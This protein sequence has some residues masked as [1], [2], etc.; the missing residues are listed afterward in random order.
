MAIWRHVGRGNSGCAPSWPSGVNPCGKGMRER[1]Y[2]A[3]AKDSAANDGKDSRHTQ[4]WRYG[5]RRRAG[6]AGMQRAPRRYRP[7][8]TERQDAGP[9][10]RGR[11]RG[12]GF[13]RRRCRGVGHSPLDHAAGRRGRFCGGAG[14]ENRHGRAGLRRHECRCAGNRAAHCGPVP[15]GP[16]RGRRHCRP[17]SQGAEADPV[18]RLRGAGGRHGGAGLGP[19]RRASAR[20]RDRQGVGAKDALFGAQQGLLGAP[21]GRVDGGRTRRD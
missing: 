8:G 3:V 10:G 6:L 4:P 20:S 7:F 9:C 11:V 14:R 16:L 1:R 2:P 13:A 15:G 19:D 17:V 21:G 5:A 18:L 12:P